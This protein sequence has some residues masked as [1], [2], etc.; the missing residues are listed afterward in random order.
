MIKRHLCRLWLTLDIVVWSIGGWLAHRFLSTHALVHALAPNASRY[1]TWPLVDSDALEI[2]RLLN[3]VGLLRANGNCAL[4]AGITFRYLILLGYTPRF[5][6]GI[7]PDAG[8]AWV[9]LDG[10]VVNDPVAHLF[11]PSVVLKIRSGQIHMQ[12]CSGN[13]W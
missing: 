4:H 3:R 12:R 8:H 6:I 5:I 11:R 13:I 7:T 1:A 9:E 2:I 10:Q